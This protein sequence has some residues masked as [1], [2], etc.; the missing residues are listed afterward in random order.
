MNNKIK[1]Y[2][3]LL[4]DLDGTILDYSKS[5]TAALFS[6][7]KHVF[8]T[9]PP[10]DLLPVY[11]KINSSLWALFERGAIEIDNL[12]KKRFA[13]M[14]RHFDLDAD[15]AVFSTQYLQELRRGGYLLKGALEVLNFCSEKYRLGAITNGIGDVQRSRLN[16]AGISHFF[17]TI[18]ISNDVGLAKPDP[19]IFKIA[20]ENMNLHD[21]KEILM[22]G[23]SLSSD[24]LGG[25]NAGIDTC[26]INNNGI[27]EKD[28]E[29]LY[30]IYNISEL[31]EIL[32]TECRNVK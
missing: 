10:N 29:P 23:D 22:I 4:F 30:T 2:K 28:I 9:L 19:G 7:Y 11:Q 24:I 17:E 3:A 5:E 32:N 16:V 14:F 18:V 12:K 6:A 13:E 8:N 31:M 20:F 21:K 1:K 25:I 27:D 15:P 26:W